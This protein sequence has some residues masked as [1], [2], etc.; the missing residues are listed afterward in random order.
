MPVAKMKNVCLDMSAAYQLGVRETFKEAQ[1]VFDCFQV[2]ALAKAA[3]DSVRRRYPADFPEE[4]HEK[5]WL[6]LKGC[7]KLTPEEPEEGRRLC[8]VK[9]HTGNAC[10]QVDA[11]RDILQD[12]DTVVAQTLLNCWCG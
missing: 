11:L 3:S 7:E 8:R 6:L 4:L 12:D 1:M 9:L 2:V 5:R 10:K